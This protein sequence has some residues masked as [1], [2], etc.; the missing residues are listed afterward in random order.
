M[1][2]KANLK[3]LQETII[4]LSRRNAIA[5]VVKILRKT[6]DA[7]IALILPHLKPD[8]REHFIDLLFR[9]N[10]LGSVLFEVD[11][12]LAREILSLMTPEEIAKIC[13]DLSMDQA[14]DL[15]GY[16]PEETQNKIIDAS[17]SVDA[18][19][20]RNLLRYDRNTAGGLMSLDYFA[21]PR[22]MS[23]DE[24][25]RLIQHAAQ[26]QEL[27]YLYVVD[28]DQ[29]LRGVISLRSLLTVPGE[30]SLEEL[31]NR[32]V[33]KISPLAMKDEV[34]RTVARYDLLSLPVVDE[35]NRLIGLITVD[36]VIDVIRDMETDDYLKMAGTNIQELA[37]SNRILK[38][39]SLR[40]P[41]LLINFCGGLFTGI[42]LWLFNH[43][44]SE[45]IALVSFVP[46]IAGMGGNVGTQSTS[47]MVRG[48]A[49]GTVDSR[50][51]VSDVAK[52]LR[53]GLVMGAACGGLVGGIGAI[54]QGNPMLG[55]V[56]GMAMLCAIT[57]AAVMGV[58]IPIMFDK[59]GIDPALAA[60]P[61]VTT[62]ND[63]TGVFIY[64]SLATLLLKYL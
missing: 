5:N 15:I 44:L 24:A 61:L 23:V 7:D 4:K 14:V 16:L 42:I 38:V 13:A 46:V 12:P 21:L 26:P 51:I 59:A 22:T 18:R 8:E 33:H 57:V 55:L 28:D 48:L 32:D 40:L 3:I 36:D 2:R 10:R 31:M 39:V 60:G 43:T 37:H 54:W 1:S 6:H 49:T 30:T 50:R 11:E 41:W 29:T 35:A 17:S 34:A 52:E 9:E 62:S 63:V 25:I 19:H 56:V 47:I 64:L 53:V 58:I 45:I 27:L 20:L